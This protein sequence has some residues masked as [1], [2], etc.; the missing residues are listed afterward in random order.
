MQQ[1]QIL[2]QAIAAGDEAALNT[3][4]QRHGL[5]ILNYLIGQLHDRA[6]AE[7]VLQDVMVAVWQQAGR[8]RG[9]SQVKT[10]MLA[11]ARRQAA[12]AYHRQQTVHH[13][14]DDIADEVG[15][16]FEDRAEYDDLLDAI[17]QLPLDQQEALDLVFYRGYS[18][19]EAAK[20]LNISIN[21][22]K[23]RLYRARQTLRRA[24]SRKERQ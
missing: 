11:I 18:G 3:L 10:W 20:H 7:D 21:T 13:P 15:R 17:N 23:S 16:V 14:L 9:D 12:K 22:F 8:F 2:I 6:V 24:L 1:D 19:V 5:T 4:Y